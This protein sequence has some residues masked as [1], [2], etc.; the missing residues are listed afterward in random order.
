MTEK[1]QPPF[2][3]CA[4]ADG[5][6]KF[7]GEGKTERIQYLA[8]NYTARFS[9]PEEKV[10]AE[11]WAELIYKYEY[12]PERIR[13]EVKVPRRTPND[14]AD[15][16]IY[17]DRDEELKAPYFV[18]ECKRADVSDAEFTQS[19]EQACGNRANLA[20]LFCGA[21][22]GLTRR[23]LRFDK[24]PPGE[25][26]RNILPDI[27]V[28]YGKPS[29]WRFYKNVPGRDLVA[30]PR[31]ELRAAIRKCHQTLWEGGR[32]SPIAAFGEFC[33]IIFVKHRDE[34]NRERKDGE[35]YTFQRRSEETAAELAVRIHRLYAY[36]Q[37]LE[38]DVFT[39][40]INVD[41]PI[42]AQV[43]EHLEG[44]SLDR[45]ELDT[46]GV[47]F[48]EFMGGFFKGDFGQYFTPRELI[49]F[50]VE[51]LNPERK[52]LVLDP[53][54][55]SGGFLLYALD[56]VRREA[57]RRFPKRLTDPQQSV[58]H[59]TY[60]HDFAEKNLFGVEI[61]EE[62]ARVAKMNM[63]I[64]DD[65]HTNIVGHDALDFF[66][67]PLDSEGNPKGEKRPY[68]YDR[69]KTLREEK[70]DII[71]TN[72]PFGSVVKRSEKGEGY[73]EQ[74]DLRNYIGKGMTGTDES[75]LSESDAKRGAKSAKERASIKTEILFLERVHSFLKPGTGRVAI[76]LPDGILTN[77]S[78][79]GVRDWLLS[80]FQLLAVVSLPQ[81][82]F[83][84]YD[85]GVKASIVFLRR[86]TED[87]TVPD[88]APIFMALAENIGY[89]ATGRKTFEVTVEKDVPGVERV[90]LLHCDLFDFRV[91]Y[92]WSTANPKKP[93][94]SERHREIIPDTGLVKQWRSFEKDPKPFFV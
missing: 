31:E 20:A 26:D 7:T 32:R 80:H 62:L 50:A 23:F 27:P 57:D 9:D 92:E 12:R 47:A 86:L 37:Q 94:W 74:F 52:Q 73:L 61:N 82:A 25:R 79:Q 1:P 28:R 53:A 2:L 68:L 21:I 41:P 49:G 19:I 40:K 10:R 67:R 87:E 35:P 24:F 69:N 55:G 66:E 3:K 85:A 77:S 48:E 60:W 76:V 78:L 29:D 70:F 16:V 36:E 89:D 71:L 45:T 17:G 42:L 18:F 8:A 13:F 65:G 30:I 22:A 5:L 14:L 15:L 6:V 46:K 58:E 83:A 33:K 11:F 75:D 64:H 43:V 63:I 72:P 4:I 93:D 88:D 54:C 90:E 84:H 39:D 34:K 81:F 56:H 91:Y 51:I 59:W 44:I 38:P